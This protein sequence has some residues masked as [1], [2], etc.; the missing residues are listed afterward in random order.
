MVAGTVWITAVAVQL[1]SLDSRFANKMKQEFSGSQC[2][3]CIGQHTRNM[4]IINK[5][6]PLITNFGSSWLIIGKKDVYTCNIFQDIMQNHWNITYLKSNLHVFLREPLGH[7]DSLSKSLMFIHQSFFKIKGKITSL[8]NIGNG[9]TLLFRFLYDSFHS[10][11][12][13]TWLWTIDH[14]DLHLF[15]IKNLGH[16]D[17]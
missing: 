5:K 13:I 12:K 17:S 1:S 8:W 10:K 2:H 4:N 9:P 6:V 15:R 16:T 11:R 3:T 14:C 7:T